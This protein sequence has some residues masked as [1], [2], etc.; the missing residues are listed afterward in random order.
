MNWIA[1]P[2][3]FPREWNAGLVTVDLCDISCEYCVLERAAGSRLDAHIFEREGLAGE[4][5]PWRACMSGCEAC[6]LESAT[7]L[8]EG[9]Y[10]AW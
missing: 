8:T 3:P 5:P 10:H 1:G 9:E 4:D 6:L 2:E 7:D